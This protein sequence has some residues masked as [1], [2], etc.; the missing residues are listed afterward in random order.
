MLQLKYANDSDYCTDK[1]EKNII[2][3]IKDNNITTYSSTEEI[4]HNNTN[5]SNTIT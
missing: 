1:D 5:I 2:G 4:L 3:D